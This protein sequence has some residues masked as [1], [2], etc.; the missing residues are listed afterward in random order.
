MSMMTHTLII[1]IRSFWHSSAGR[2]GGNVLDALVYRD[3]S[4]LPVLP[5]RHIKGLLRDATLRAE[6]WGW[7]GFNSGTT[8]ELFGHKP[9]DRQSLPI[10]KGAL[11]ISDAKLARSTSNWLQ[12]TEQGKALIPGLFR[13]IYSTAIDHETST[14]KEKSLRG[15]EVTIPLK[16]YTSISVLPGAEAPVDWSTRLKQVFP[17]IDSVGAYRNR[18]LGRAVL[19][20]DGAEC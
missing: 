16:L 12:R 10:V 7:N 20:W 14:A 3:N 11:K 2:D 4:G 9:E 15:I 18:G 1:D 13:N 5:G 8:T 17:L 6:T 19:Q